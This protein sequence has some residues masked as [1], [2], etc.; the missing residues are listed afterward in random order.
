MNK[1]I[2]SREFNQDT[3]SA[4]RFA[5]DGPVI[6]TDRGKPAHVLMTYQEF[7]RL[8]DRKQRVTDMLGIKS[9]LETELESELPARTDYPRGEE[10]L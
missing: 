3:S 4:K 5:S 6:I 7:S 8:T 1:V 2:S 10:F 9:E